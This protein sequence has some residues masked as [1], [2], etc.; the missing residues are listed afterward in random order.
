MKEKNKEILIIDYDSD[1]NYENEIISNYIL[2]KFDIK[3]ISTEF[4]KEKSYNQYSL[5]ILKSALQKY[6]RRS[7]IDKAIYFAIEICLF[8]F[9][10]NDL[11]R[12]RII[13]N[14]I[15]R[16][17]IIFL[18]DVGLSC[19]NIIE[20]IDK[21]F[22]K[23][24]TRNP[25]SFLII[26]LNLVYTM[27]KNKHT[28]VCSHYHHLFTLYKDRQKDINEYLKYFPNVKKYFNLVKKNKSNFG[29][30]EQSIENKTCDIGFWSINIGVLDDFKLKNSNIKK[31]FEPLL[32]KNIKNIEIMMKWTK[33]L[34]A[35]KEG[36]LP[37]Y[38]SILY[39][40][41][42][43]DIKK[44]GQI[45]YLKDAQII[46]YISINLEKKFEIDDYIIDMHTYE[47]K[48]LG[49]NTKNFIYEGSLV[50]N[51]FY[52]NKITEEWHKFYNF[53]KL[54]CQE[55]I[56][57][58]NFLPEDLND[59]KE[60]ERVFE[61]ESDVFELITRAQL[62][63]S[64]YKQ[65]TYYAI[66]KR[67]KSNKITKFVKGPYLTF[68][69]I[70]LIKNITEIRKLLNLSYV[71]FEILELIPNLLVS[72]LSTRNNINKENNKKYYFL[73]YDNLIQ[74]DLITKKHSSKIWPSTEVL[75]FDKM[76]KYK[77][78]LI[79]NKNQK[80]LKD[81]VNHL[82][83]RAILGIGDLEDRNFLPIDDKLYSLDEESLNDD[84]NILKE[85]KK[86]K[87]EIV[88]RIIDNHKKYFQDVLLCWKNII[89]NTIYTKE[90][91]DNKESNKISESLKKLLEKAI[92]RIDNNKFIKIILS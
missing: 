56:I 76:E 20:Y 32:I 39:Y 67:H 29:N 84:L 3:K 64:K 4:R 75:D 21:L 1:D 46:D 25:K 65:D 35:L 71:N 54:L 36:F 91:K 85:L 30:Y 81:Y 5:D 79:K 43:K 89:E 22:D 12:K 77:F 49:K 38:T 52:I 31:I 62:V 61:K 58:E 14:F 9:K 50:K 18:E 15:H 86:E 6:I 23:L 60:N 24:F 72:P 17:Q 34:S 10:E 73:I 42:Q 90:T 19:Y 74:D 68:E 40:L 48:I 87:S 47:G 11:N 59:D 41:F 70:E 53:S 92:N 16:L 44:I 27:C 51:E 8:I 37:Y 80:L 82:M 28:R 55:N 7:E 63:T 66:D 26:F 78:S 57:D 69:K 33:E 83:F 13:T 88:V 45:Y 2:N